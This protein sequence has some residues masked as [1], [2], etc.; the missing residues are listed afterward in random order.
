MKKILGLDIG[1]NSIGWALIE[2]NTEE[3]KG[4]IIDAGSR[5]IPMSQDIIG[6]FEKGNKVSQTAQRTTFRSIRRLRERHLLRRE[7]LLRILNILAFLPEHFSKKIDFTQKVGQ[8]MDNTEPKIAYRFNYEKKRNEFYFIQSFNEMLTDFS[9]HQ[10]DLVANSKKIPYDWTIYYLRNKALTQKIEKEELAWLLLNFNQKRGYFQLRG[11]DDIEESKQSEFHSLKVVDVLDSGDKK[12]K[13]EIWYNIV[14]ENG[15][16]YKRTSKTLLDWIGKT[17]EFIVTTE[18]NEDGSI[19]TNKDGT[20]KRSFKAV[21]SKI[22]W[23]A[24]K[25]STEEKIANSNTTVGTYIYSTLLKTP[26]QKINGKLV[27]TIERKFYRSELIAILNK[28]VEFHSELKDKRLLQAC[29]EELYSNNESHR[30]NIINNGFVHLFTNDII[31]YQRPLKSKKSLISNCRYE[32]RFYLKNG[33]LIPVPIKCVAKSHPRFQEFR[34]WQWIK[35]I[36]IY[37]KE[38]EQDVTNTLLKNEEDWANLFIW[39]NNKKEIKQKAFLKYPGFELKKNTEKYRWNF[40]EDKPYPCNETRFQIISRFSKIEG[41]PNN[42]ITEEIIESIWHLLYSVED[43]DE[44]KKALRSFSIK[45]QLGEAF[46]E[47][48]SK[49][50]RI[51]KEYGAYSLKAINKLLPLMRMGEY[52]KE[53]DILQHV[54]S[55]YDNVRLTIEKIAKNTKE[56]KADSPLLQKLKNIND[57]LASYKGLDLYLACYVAYGRHSEEGESKKWHTPDDI[58]LLEQHSLRNPI[59]EQVINETLLVVKDIWKIYGN[60]NEGFF[61]EIHIELGRE[62]KNPKEKRMQMYNQMNENENTNLRM[63]ALLAE[64]LNDQKIE[65][66]RPYS[67][68]Q[69]EILKI[70]E[71][72]IL[73]SAG[74]I[75]DDILKIS[76]SGQPSNSELTKYKLWLQQGYISPYTGVIIPLHKLFT[77]AYEIEHIIP[78]SKFFDD[79]FSNKVI[80]EAEVNKLKNNQ[81]AFEFIQNHGGQIV[82]LNFGNSVEIKKVQEYENHI[83][84]YFSKSRSKL[85]KLLL[86]EIPDKFNERQL[87]DTRYISKVV[88][89]LLSNIV[90]E[91]NEKETTSKHVLSSN[92]NITSILKQD[93]GLNEVWN[94]IISP[95]FMRLNSITNSTDFGRIN[96]TTHKFLPQVPLQ[97]QKGFKKKRIDHR[98]H[99]IDALV[100]ACATR[101]HINYLNNEYA[102]PDKINIR[103]DLRNILCTKKYS[104]NKDSNYQWIFKSPWEQFTLD[105]KNQLSKTIVSFKQNNRVINKTVN[106]FQK[107]QENDQGQMTKMSVKQTKGDSWA[108]RKPLHRDTVYGSVQL[109]LIKPVSLS[110]A[111]DNW[112]SIVDKQLKSKINELVNQQYDKKKQIKYFKDNKIDWKNYDF[113]KTNIYYLDNDNVASRENIDESFNTDHIKKITDSGIQK[114]LINHLAKYNELKDGKVIEHPD[115][116]FSPDG[117]D[118]MNKNIIALNNRKYHHAIFKVRTFEPKGNKFNMGATGNKKNKFVEAAKGTNLFFSVYI[119]N[120]GKRNFASIPL[121]IV[122]EREKQGL[123]PVPEKN[124]EDDKLLF[125]LSPNDLVFVPSENEIQYFNSNDFNLI[126]TELAKKIYK[127]V[128]FSRSQIFFVRHDISIPIINKL[129]FSPLN[130]TEKSIDGIMIK[131][132]CWKLKVDRLGKI[133]ILK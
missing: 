47:L 89:N 76:K 82:A 121:N 128:S 38:T 75:S 23:I 15:W 74:E 43:K 49:Y 129:E 42:F 79:S 2:Q 84:R 64:M 130:K 80:C 53:K 118:D 77:P 12:G 73:N 107:W 51:E 56:E 14:L 131:D 25:K 133:K 8:F 41:L 127:V 120:L 96:P 66:V 94:E 90:R 21:D 88:K 39:L 68:S 125:Y 67:P 85:T 55:Y 108:I 112:K 63:K 59:V 60:G 30:L 98:H 58:Q 34:L 70:Y 31:F 87:N 19:K 105:V 116:A 110:I 99:A 35:N 40:V 124:E 13:D 11:E 65:N 97:L 62:M 111:L 7:R 29:I 103:H 81:L 101:N 32:K 16:V 132:L 117:L 100:I 50:P 44:I 20:I 122:I 26:N 27:S 28:Q 61:N 4:N 72:G 22:D 69:Q 83:K 5:I 109:Q 45:H 36:K 93:W 37:F 9:L 6:D 78:Q 33:D 126:T 57:D 48:F 46:I 106:R 18:L 114:I 102:N 104:N 91:E 24:I 123:C 10:P 1:T 3:I 54:S 52:W 86:A 95:R 115:L 113:S 92:G 17:K 71:D 119:N